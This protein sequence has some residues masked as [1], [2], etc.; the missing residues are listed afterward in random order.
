[1]QY[2]IADGAWMFGKG[3]C[4]PDNGT[5]FSMRNRG[6]NGLTLTYR[7]ALNINS[8]EWFGFL[9]TDKP[10]TLFGI[11]GNSLI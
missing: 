9:F 6:L 10:S 4:L 3:C 8:M 7:K 2:V 5:S 1:M 11:G